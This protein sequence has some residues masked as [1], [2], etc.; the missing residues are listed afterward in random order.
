M[1]MERKVDLDLWEHLVLLELLDHKDL[2]V[3]EE[4]RY[5]MVD[6]RLYNNTFS[7]CRAILVPLVVRESKDSAELKDP[8]VSTE[9]R[10]KGRQRT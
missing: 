2:R 8:R 10:T 7:L 6:T 5:A 3:L 4:R 9:L 1:V